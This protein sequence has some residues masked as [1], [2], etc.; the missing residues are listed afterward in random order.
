MPRS[1][2]RS[3]S[4]GR[5]S[6]SSRIP[7]LW[8][9]SE[10]SYGAMSASISFS[11]TASA[12]VGTGAKAAD[13]GFM[14]EDVGLSDGTTVAGTFQFNSLGFINLW[15]IT[16]SD[17]LFPGFHYV[18]GTPGG[19]TTD[20]PLDSFAVFNRTNFNGYLQLVFA[21]GLLTT[22]PDPGGTD[23]LLLAGTSYE[24]STFGRLDGSC[25]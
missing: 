4:F 20:N 15:D 2:A 16:P 6:F 19:V 21:N 12:A 1:N 13:R 22:T 8:H 3:A 5:P 10:R 9:I 24:C 23:A 14:L 11:N 25:S 17:G 7:A 18:T